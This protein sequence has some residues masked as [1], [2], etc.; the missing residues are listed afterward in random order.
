MAYYLELTVRS[1]AMPV[2][3]AEG[4]TK[5]YLDVMMRYF[6][7]VLRYEFNVTEAKSLECA[8]QILTLHL[9]DLLAIALEAKELPPEILKVLSAVLELLEKYKQ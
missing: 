3:P 1:I 8:K 2:M 6:S 5:A 4:N 9:P 7:S